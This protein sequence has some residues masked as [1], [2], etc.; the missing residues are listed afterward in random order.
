MSEDNRNEYYRQ[1]M[2]QLNNVCV[3]DNDK[4]LSSDEE[5]NI[6]ENEIN[7][8]D[9]VPAEQYEETADHEFKNYVNVINIFTYYYKQTFNI[10][11][12][13]TIFDDIPFDDKTATNKC[14][15]FIFGEIYRYE[16]SNVSDKDVLYNP[17]DNI[18]MESYK[19]LYCL[20][21]NSEPLY[22]SP[23]VLPLIT[24]LAEMD[25]LNINWTIIN[26]LE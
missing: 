12:K 14:M 16:K 25:W 20:M 17:D 3:A 26:I 8:D 15:E 6:A 18:I 22:I 23:F 9:Y 21:I 11:Q 2:D 24:Q 1:I 7:I 5:Y 10:Q 19:E 4:N 13:I